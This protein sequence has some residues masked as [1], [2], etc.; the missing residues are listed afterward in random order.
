MMR[1]NRLTY[2]CYLVFFLGHILQGLCV[3]TSYEQGPN[4]RTP[5]G[6]Q[7]QTHGICPVKVKYASYASNNGDECIHSV[8]VL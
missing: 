1:K 2:L 3:L 8:R 4:F 7:N 5:S 6:H